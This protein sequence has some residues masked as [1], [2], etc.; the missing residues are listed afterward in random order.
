MRS[1][2]LGTARCR[3]LA[4]GRGDLVGEADV[5]A[6]EPVSRDQVSALERA[7][8]VSCVVWPELAELSGWRHGRCV[9]LSVGDRERAGQRKRA[10][11]GHA[12]FHATRLQAPSCSR[13]TDGDWVV[14]SCGSAQI[15]VDWLGT[16]FIRNRWIKRRLCCA[17][18][19]PEPVPVAP[20]W[21]ACSRTRTAN[22][23]GSHPAEGAEGG[24]PS[25]DI[26]AADCAYITRSP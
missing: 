24:N 6:D 21:R 10:L 26:G 2:A 11:A 23:R 1:S 14:F 25:S 19:E 17:S 5:I 22:R 7:C 18:A 9:L 20:G 15:C 13:P 16:P 12:R 4:T 3:R 8:L